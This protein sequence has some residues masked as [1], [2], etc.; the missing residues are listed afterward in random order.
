[1]L[2]V[3]VLATLA[4]IGIKESL[5]VNLV[6]VAIKLFV[7]LFVIIAG[8][9]YIKGSNLLAVHPAERAGPERRRH[10]HHPAVPGDLRVQPRRRS[11]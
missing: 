3:V 11:A 8:L 10:H 7:V 4:T 2:L 5:R 9:F 6:L 1:M